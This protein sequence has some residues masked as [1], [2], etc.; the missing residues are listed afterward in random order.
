MSD[1]TLKIGAEAGEVLEKFKEIGEEGGEHLGGK[2]SEATKL[3]AIGF[4]ALSAQVGVALLEY[5]KQEKAANSLSTALQDQGI[6]STELTENYKEQ[7]EAISELTGYS[8]TEITQAQAVAQSFIGNVPITKDLTKAIA[9][10]A[11]K[12]GTDLPT[13]AETLG[14]AI[15]NGTGQ[16]KR[17]G[18]QFNATDTEATRYQKTL[19]FVAI[20][21]GDMAEA[22]NK[23]LGGVRGLH[24]A[25]EEAQ[26][27]LG[28][29][30]APAASYVIELLTKLLKPSR[31]NAEFM[32]SLKAAFIVVG[33]AVTGVVTAIGT[34]GVIL[35]TV[36]AAFAA[37]TAVIGLGIL[38]ILGITAG[39]VAAGLAIYKLATD[40]EGSAARIKK[41]LEGLSTATK[42]TFG[43]LKTIIS[44]VMHGSL[45]SV[46]EGWGEIKDASV[47]GA[48]EATANVDKT[49]EAAQKK[50]DAAKKAAFDAQNEFKK[51]HDQTALDLTESKEEQ[52]GLIEKGA[53]KKRLDLQTKEIQILTAATKAKNVKEIA[54]NRAQLD[55]IYKQEE[56]QDKR[57]AA[58]KQEFDAYMLGLQK[59]YE[60]KHNGQKLIYTSDETKL[61]ESSYT[62]Q[63]DL[64]EQAAKEK[65][66]TQLA[67]H[68]TYLE[69]QQK[70]GTAFAEEAAIRNREDV[71]AAEATADQLVGLENSKVGALHAIGKAALLAKLP[72]TLADIEMNTAKGAIAAFSSLAAIPFVGPILGGIAAAAMIAYGAEQAVTAIGAATS[73]SQGGLVE[74]VGSGDVIPAM[75][76]PGELVVPKHSFESVINS[77]ARD[78]NNSGNGTVNG[79]VGIKVG[80]NGPQASRVLTVSQNEDKALGI[81]RARS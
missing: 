69:N 50:Q 41:V 29:K 37:A 35:P 27:A 42:G 10:L 81:S 62:S 3:A 46:K 61:L 54:A 33:L 52:E 57:D 28:A 75:L 9:D 24:T 26:V 25:F 47:K 53:S 51:Q 72:L 14:K 58:R 70:Y 40:W 67:N 32:T 78:R 5:G 21:A 63:S 11:A 43:G 16:L 39:V 7:A 77:V 80:F 44:G 13:A 49:L 17:M 48:K 30:F 4:T 18:I 8:Q 64:D 2:L 68:K 60:E 19:D 1:I 36:T 66:Q 38:P 31:E 59:D 15:G 20:K 74:G 22:T 79:Q 56:D 34:L 65:I 23:G 71:K 6:F 55:A 76:E 12:Q 73:F 45:D